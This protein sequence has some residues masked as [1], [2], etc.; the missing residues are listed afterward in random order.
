MIC[1]EG[2]GIAQYIMDYATSEEAGLIVMGAKGHSQ[3]E[4]LL[5]GSV[6][7]KLLAINE[8]IPTLVVK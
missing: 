2:A 5:M 7:E 8:S 1:R 4:L 3:V 6:T